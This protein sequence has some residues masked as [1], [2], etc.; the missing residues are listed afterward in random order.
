[1][2]LL[3]EDGTGVAGANTYADL[4][5]VD[6][7]HL[8]R[9]NDAWGVLDPLIKEQCIHRAMDYLETVFIALWKGYRVFASQP[10]CWPRSFVPVVDIYFVTQTFYPNNFLPIQLKNVVAELAIRAID[11]VLLPDTEQAVAVE[12][13]E[14]IEVVYNKY[15][16]KSKKFPLIQRMLS[17]FL[18]SSSAVGVE[19]VR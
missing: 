11:N 3:V 18:Q 5:F 13:I 14:G 10:L 6:G 19:M 12:K 17:P 2:T 16:P 8:I 4:A 1:M 15:S 9:G 7:Y